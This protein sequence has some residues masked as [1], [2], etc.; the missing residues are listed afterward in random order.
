M[1]RLSIAILTLVGFGFIAPQALA[2]EPTVP[3]EPLFSRHVV[4][5]FSKLGC[6]AGACHGAVQGQNGFRLSL[7]GMDPA[8]DHERLVRDS[9]GRRISTFDPDASLLLLKATGRATHRGGMRT[10]PGSADYRILRHWLAQGAKLDAVEKSLVNRLTVSPQEKLGKA[11]EA[12]QLKVEATF[13]DGTVE[14]VTGLCTFESNNKDV[15]DVDRLG[16]VRLTGVGD[17]PIVIRY[18]ALP[19]MASVLVPGKPLDN[20][21]AVVERSFI[22]KHLFAKLRKLNIEPSDEC[23]DATFLRRVSLDVTG[24]LP[25]ADD[26]RKF[27]A[28][29]DPARRAKKIDHLLEQPGYSAVW[30]TKFADLLKAR[31]SYE[32]FTHQPAQ[33]SIRQFYDWT[34]ARLKENTPYDEMVARMLLATSL[35]GRSREEWINEVIDS[36]SDTF[37]GKIDRQGYANRKTLDLYWH[38]F[39]S[40]GVKGAVQFA[41]SFLGLRLQCAQCHRHPSDIWTQDDVLSLSNFFMRIKANTGVMSV[42]EASQVKK[43]MGT[44]LTPAEK[45]KLTEQAKMLADKGKKLQEQS[46]AKKG[47]K[48]ETDK[49]QA[50]ATALTQRAGA[51]TRAIKILEV[52]YVG[53]VKGNAFG[54]ASVTSPLGTQKSETFRLL[55]ARENVKIADDQDPRELLASWLRSPDNPFFAKAIVNRVWAHYFG[56][57]IVDPP[58]DLSPLNPPTHPELFQELADTFVKQ[59]YDLKWLHRT[60]M[61]SAAYQRSSR[62]KPTNQ[63][64]SRNFASFYPRRMPAEVLVDALGQATGVPD[65]LKAGGTSVA[66]AIEIPGT[67]ADRMVGNPSVELAFTIFGRP[68]RNAEALCDCDRESRP[69]LVQSLYRANHPDLLKKISAP[70]GR[71]AEL[72][73]AH[74][75]DAK[76]IDELYLWTLSRLPT[77]AERQICVEHVRTSSSVS[78]GYQGLF[79]SLLNT[80]EF[81][82]N[83]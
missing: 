81:I 13:A 19:V 73:K 23:D 55:G 33:A 28:E 1:T 26:V 8:L 58:D 27:L 43:T 16:E 64:D 65:V 40:V 32:D 72:V 66:R 75:D 71:L 2:G 48:A 11:G 12:Y 69:A 44:G 22:D 61:N 30:A 34:R 42:K 51:I 60:I 79:W 29:P 56:R 10:T 68:T 70:K 3:A 39:D 54:W 18:R 21:P 76:R 57:G 63:F 38:R 78:R 50:E 53:P 49:L 62:T 6:N 80:R 15:A 14:D 9:A 59:K 4:P 24:A 74:G 31:I 45:N 36:Y 37:A 46:K 67:I 77:D 7:F 17:A 41:H 5:I 35:D 20:F 25:T 83:H 47:N 82:L 52:S